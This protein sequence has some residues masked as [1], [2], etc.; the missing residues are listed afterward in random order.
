MTPEDYISNS[1]G[2]ASIVTGRIY[3][4][5]VLCGD[6]SIYGEYVQTNKKKDN[7]MKERSVSAMTMRATGNVQGSFYYY[8]L[9]TGRRLRRG[10]CTP[11]PVPQEVI[12]Q[13]HAIADK[14]N[15]PTGFTYTRC[16][17]SIFKNMPDEQ[18]T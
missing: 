3:D 8:S 7:T 9:A 18:V 2:P 12:D 17:G 13:V 1:L 4:Y 10:Q 5:N 15:A 14:Q 16:D 11:L 6:G